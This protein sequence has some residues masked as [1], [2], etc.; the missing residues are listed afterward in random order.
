MTQ[1]KTSGAVAIFDQ[2]FL[3]IKDAANELDINL[4]LMRSY[5]DFDPEL[6]R[7]GDNSLFP[8]SYKEGPGV[9]SRIRI[10]KSDIEKFK[11]AAV[12][13]DFDSLKIPYDQR[14]KK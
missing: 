10:V 2:D 9:T 13:G 5:V 4:K 7:P 12:N 8:Y 14:F 11:I 1:N 6:G 3:T